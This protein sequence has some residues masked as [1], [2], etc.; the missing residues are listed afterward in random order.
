MNSS[1]IRCVSYRCFASRS[2]THTHPRFVVPCDV[3]EPEQTLRAEQGHVPS[4]VAMGDLYYYGAYGLARD[5][6]QVLSWFQR[7]AAAPQ[8]SRR[9]SSAHEL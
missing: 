9:P 6:A 7:A 8:T 3:F 1:S 2:D 5:Q 4:M